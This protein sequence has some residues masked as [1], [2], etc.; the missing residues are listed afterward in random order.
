MEEK[1]SPNDSPLPTI[2]TKYHKTRNNFPFD[3]SYVFSSGR[4]LVMT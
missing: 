2:K 3:K 1:D 4:M